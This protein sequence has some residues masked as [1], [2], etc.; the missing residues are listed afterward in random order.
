M[1]QSGGRRTP[2]RGPRSAPRSTSRSTGRRR[3]ATSGRARRPVAP[4]PP[5]ARARLTS[6]A[7]VLVLIVA[8]LA[9]SYASSLR[10]Y[11]QQ[12]AHLEDAQS[13]I[14]AS[15]ASIDALETER[16]QL[17][18]PAYIEQQARERLGYVRP[19]DR[20]FVVLRDGEPLDVERSL[21]DPSG[22]DPTEPPAWWDDAWSS[23]QLAGEPPRRADPPPLTRVESPEGA[24]SEEGEE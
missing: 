2:G 23:L 24:P 20:P 4:A 14:A 6:R 16:E 19:G 5:R 1:S 18:D 21:S 17:D 22:A 8:V 10:A 11:L 7:A 15:E 3:P 13:R 12:R 9:V